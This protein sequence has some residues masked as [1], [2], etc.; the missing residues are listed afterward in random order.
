M[1]NK[2]VISF[3]IN[4]LML[5][6]IVLPILLIIILGL[7]AWRVIRKKWIHRIFTNL[8]YKRNPFVADFYEQVAVTLKKLGR[9]L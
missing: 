1:G 6:E 5:A 9:R 4:L 3:V 7:F 8:V 2:F